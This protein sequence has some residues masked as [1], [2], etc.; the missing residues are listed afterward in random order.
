MRFSG[1]LFT[2]HLYG[3]RRNDCCDKTNCSESYSTAKKALS[4]VAR[5]L[6]LTLSQLMQQAAQELQSES[7]NPDIDAL[8]GRISA[9]TKEAN[10]ALDD[11]FEFIAES[12]KRIEAMSTACR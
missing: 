11:A 3:S 8:L 10:N 2:R 6:G 5:R 7:D 9:S 1:T 4:A 12:N